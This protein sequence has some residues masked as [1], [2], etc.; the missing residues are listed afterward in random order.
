MGVFLKSFKVFFSSQLSRSGDVF[1][2]IEPLLGRT[3][4]LRGC[5]ENLGQIMFLLNSV[6]NLKLRTYGL[7]LSGIHISEFK[8]NG[9]SSIS[10][11]SSQ[12]KRSFTWNPAS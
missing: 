1:A 2:G 4:A 7:S 11:F 9:I 10:G 12:Q 8:L 3:V 5:C 6:V